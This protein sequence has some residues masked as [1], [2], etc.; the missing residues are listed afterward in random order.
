MKTTT[1]TFR[2]VLKSIRPINET[3]SGKLV[4]G[5]YGG[6]GGDPDDDDA[7]VH[8]GNKVTVSGPACSCGCTCGC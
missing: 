1:T 3:E 5:F 2:D 6:K 4:G 8:V 7:S